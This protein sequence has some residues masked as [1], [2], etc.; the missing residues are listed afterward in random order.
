[1]TLRDE[2]GRALRVTLYRVVLLVLLAS[3]PRASAA[4]DSILPDSRLTPGAVLSTD[5]QV[6]CV[7]GYSKTVRHT[8]GKL[9]ASIYREY[10]ID[11]KSGTYAIDHLIPLSI[12]GADVAENLWPAS[13]Q[14]RPWN[15]GVKDRLELKLHRLVCKKALDIRVA[16]KAIADNWIEAYKHFCPTDADCPSYGEL[17]RRDGRK[18]AQGR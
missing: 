15:K 12:G 3:M 9:K 7:I 11:K 13:L 8:S 17:K 5:V 1:M 4:E 6:V 14:T 2:S 16:Q 10:G 18:V